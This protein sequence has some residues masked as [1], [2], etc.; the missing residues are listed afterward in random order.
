MADKQVLRLTLVGRSYCSLCDKMRVSLADYAKINDISLQLAE[1]DLDDFP[2]WE[3][4]FGERVPILMLADAPNGA[5]ICHY[6]F[7][8]AAF[9]Q[10]TAKQGFSS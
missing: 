8:E 1:I 2:Q 7:D 9:M 6:H 5:E 4:K 10:H 3:D